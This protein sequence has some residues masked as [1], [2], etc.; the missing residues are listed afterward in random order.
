MPG[1]AKP[2]ARPKKAV[3]GVE[4]RTFAVV[5]HDLKGKP[6]V[7]REIFVR[8]LPEDRLAISVTETGR[9]RV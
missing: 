5:F 8:C 6:V 7:A 1:K 4:L 9:H 2:K 3:K